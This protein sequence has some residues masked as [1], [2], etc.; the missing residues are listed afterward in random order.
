[1]LVVPIKGTGN[2]YANATN[3]AGSGIL[4][5]EIINKEGKK[6]M[7]FKDLDLKL[8]LK[9]YSVTLENLFEGDPVLS[10]SHQCFNSLVNWK[11]ND[12]FHLQGQAA[13]GVLNDNRGE[14]IKIAMP[15]I[16]NLLSDY[17]LNMANKI[18]RNFEYDEVFPEA[19]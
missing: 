14:F 11:S 16:Q 19:K 13:N 15:F 8:D 4:K 18:T 1:M 17:L 2:F 9:D 6:Y 12:K 10:K 3:C 5:A 7:Q